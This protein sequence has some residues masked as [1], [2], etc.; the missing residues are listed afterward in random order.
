MITGLHYPLPLHLQPALPHLGYSRGDF[1]VAEA[2]AGELVS[3][4]MFPELEPS[5]IERVAGVLAAV[6]GGR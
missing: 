5:E 2:W 1:A 6:Y 3:L 4:P